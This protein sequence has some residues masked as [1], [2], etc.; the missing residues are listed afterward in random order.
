[1]EKGEEGKKGGEGESGAG[2]GKIYSITFRKCFLISEY[3]LKGCRSGS[4][5][6]IGSVPDSGSGLSLNTKV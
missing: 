4:G 2:T 5:N 1:M 6:F 3:S